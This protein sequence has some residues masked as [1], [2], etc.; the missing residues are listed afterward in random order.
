MAMNMESRFLKR[1][2]VDETAGAGVVARSP[3]ARRSLII[4]LVLGAI[5]AAALIWWFFL[6]AHDAAPAPAQTVPT[7]TVIV[8]GRSAV[9]NQVSATG[10]LAARREL[11]VGIPGEGGRVAAVLVE[12]GT[13]VNAG[14][15]LATVDRSVEAQQAAS[16]SATVQARAADAALAQANLDRAQRLVAR[17]F[18]SKADI[19]RLSAT[20]D[21]ANA[22]VRVAQAQ[23]REMG[24]RIGR[25]DIRAPAAGLVLTRAVEPGQVVSSGSG[26]L[27]RIARG[28]E[29]E[30]L[31]R[32]AESDLS[33]LKIGVP[34]IVIPVGGDH[35]LKGSIWQLSP[36]IDPTTRQGI[37]RIALSYDPAI[38][39]GGFATAMISSGSVDAPLLPESAVQ[40][41]ARGNYV[42]VVGP[43]NKIV[44][45]D[46]RI[47]EV[48]DV[49]IAILSGLNGHEKVVRSAG[50]FLNP[51]EKVIPE[52]I[53]AGR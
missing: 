8:P 12:P 22:N 4:K 26:T 47:G 7:V 3:G 39:P 35:Q 44:R 49:G 29:M 32:L 36:V 48:S 5:L 9:A 14:Q 40:S 30:M 37:V 10:T 31:A 43:D 24:A 28:G 45:R 17:G 46:V 23:R 2:M 19:D 50:A 16:L 33:R 20:R 18:I 51:G 41:D 34:A 15:V 1:R 21:A 42:Y 38:R 25:L 53:A 11:P 13:W 52:L 27:F 6:R